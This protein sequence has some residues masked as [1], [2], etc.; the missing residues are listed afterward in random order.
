MPQGDVQ[1]KNAALS[2][3]LADE[4]GR[5]TIK[6]AYPS[7]VADMDDDEDDDDEKSEADAMTIVVLC[8]LTPGKVNKFM[9]EASA[10]S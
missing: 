3:V 10:L 8:S 5:T 4:T 1:I 2:D 6:L 9:G 7:L